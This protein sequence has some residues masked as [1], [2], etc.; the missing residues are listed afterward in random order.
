MRP[1]P[2]LALALA[3][4]LTGCDAGN[5]AD[6]GGDNAQRSPTLV[7]STPFEGQQVVSAAATGHVLAKFDLV[8]GAWGR[9][10]GSKVRYRLQHQEFDRASGKPV[11]LPADAPWVVVDDAT[12]A[13][14]LGALE[15]R[16]DAEVPYVLTVEAIDKDGSPWTRAEANAGARVVRR[17]TV[18]KT[19]TN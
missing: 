9:C 14:S 11:L 19:W 16:T 8:G 7:V 10:A 12:K 15:P 2:P 5:R 3:L 6:P 13:V 17:F 18:H 4:A 1:L